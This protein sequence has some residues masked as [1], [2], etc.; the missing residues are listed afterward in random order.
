M[1]KKRLTTDLINS[2]SKSSKLAEE[3]IGKIDW[4]ILIWASLLFFSFLGLIIY[5]NYMVYNNSDTL[6]ESS[7]YPFLIRL[8]FSCA[9]TTFV[10][11][12]GYLLYHHWKFKTE[13]IEENKKR[14]R[15][16]I[17]GTSLAILFLI[18]YQLYE[19]YRE[20]NFI[21]TDGLILIF[22]FLNFSIP[23]ILIFQRPKIITSNLARY[24]GSLSF[25]FLIF[26][27]FLNLY[28]HSISQVSF[29]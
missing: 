26:I 18:P 27:L 11:I 3:E 4:S 6:I 28:S 12:S 24:Y 2:I 19:I 14:F 9:L 25:N 7:N 23:L 13:N 8:F 5:S 22:L 15:I 29:L 16:F 1:N 21:A 20:P 10:Y 17:F